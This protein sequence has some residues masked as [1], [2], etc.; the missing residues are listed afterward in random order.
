MASATITAAHYRGNKTFTVDQAPM[1][2][3]GAG[4]VAVRIAYCGICGTDM[5]VYHG[6]MD[7]RVGFER[8]IGHEM[9]GVIQAVGDGVD[10]LSPGAKSSGAAAGSLR[11]LPGLYGGAS[12]HLSQA[13]IFRFRY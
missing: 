8:V 13:E 1:P 7:A 2:T 6:N 3:P 5:H 11:R 10:R 4:E 12:P 9:S